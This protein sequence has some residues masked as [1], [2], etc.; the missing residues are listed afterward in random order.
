MGSAI[1]ALVN[2]DRTQHC[3]TSI[4]ISFCKYC[5][6][7][8]A[9]LPDLTFQPQWAKIAEEN[10]ISLPKA[11]FLPVE[12]Q[13]N[14]RSLLKDY[15]STM[16]KHLKSEHKDL[17]SAEYN[18]QR[19]IEAR[20]EFSNEKREQLE[21]IQANF[22]KLLSATRTLA[23]LLG[24]TVP[25]LPVVL[26]I[27]NPDSVLISGSTSNVQF[28]QWG[29]EETKSFYTQL[30]DLRPILPNYCPQDVQN[31][32]E[33]DSQVTEEI[34]DAEDEPT[35]E[36][37]SS[38]MTETTEQISEPVDDSNSA[39]VPALAKN[40]FESFLQSLTNCVNQGNFLCLVI[41]ALI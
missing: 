19:Q 10:N 38:L 14:L 9:G 11:T 2:Q 28:D 15:Y 21:V 27:C 30:P 20:G 6:F 23:D 33:K 25:D 37:T 4:I 32:E 12:K 34:L 17:R 5:G 3:N 24:E 36:I 22:E 31:P 29:D 13:Q 39:P 16:V 35:L 1:V 40:S 18:K 8:F 41:I 7:E 26:D